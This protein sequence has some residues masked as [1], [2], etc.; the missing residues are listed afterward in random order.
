MSKIQKSDI[1]INGEL[2]NYEIWSNGVVWN[3]RTMSKMAGGRD[4]N[5]YHIVSLSSHGKK[6]TRKVHK[7]VMEAFSTNYNNYPEIDHKNGDKWDNRLSN[8]EYV[9]SAE[10]TRR[11]MK[12]NKHAKTIDA[13]IARKIGKKLASGKY[14]ISEISRKMNVPQ[15]IV[16]KIKNRKIWKDITSDLDF[17]AVKSDKV[18]RGEKH[19]NSKISKKDAKLI[20]KMYNNGMRPMEISRSLKIPYKIIYHI[21]RNETWVDI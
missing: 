13:K 4:K 10:N 14:S 16:S 7:L 2:T 8:L 21:C 19:G 17:T 1:Y 11:A 18:S 6:Y 15:G 5:G 20:R 9:T 3:K 12:K